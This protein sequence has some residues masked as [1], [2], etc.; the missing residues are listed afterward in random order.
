MYLINTDVCAD[1]SLQ[2]QIDWRK[3]YVHLCHGLMVNG[4]FSV[5]ATILTVY[6]FFV[7]VFYVKSHDISFDGFL[8]LWIRWFST[9]IK[10]CSFPKCFPTFFTSS[11]LIKRHHW[12][13]WDAKNA[14]RLWHY[15]H[16][17]YVITMLG[18]W[19]PQI[20]IESQNYQRFMHIPG[21]PCNNAA[22]ILFRIWLRI[23]TFD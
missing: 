6:S 12:S 2:C 15:S 8:Y 23:H 11:W 18:K 21:P 19:Q 4:E 22:Y 7:C 20:W 1:L 16:V 3:V 10:I 14:S 9:S 13:S 5:Y 17:F